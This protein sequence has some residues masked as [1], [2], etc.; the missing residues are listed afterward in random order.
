M[1]CQFA[2][3]FL[4]H[5]AGIGAGAHQLACLVS[6]LAGQ[7]EAGLRVR[8]EAQCVAPAVQAVVEAPAM[9]AAFDEQPKVQA[10]TVS[11]ALAGICWLD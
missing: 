1:Q 9:R 4:A 7:A 10:V 3:G 6:P 5:I 11:Q 8:A 2:A